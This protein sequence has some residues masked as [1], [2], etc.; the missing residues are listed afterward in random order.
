M[1]IPTVLVLLMGLLFAGVMPYFVFRN[2]DHVTRETVP[3]LFAGAFGVGFCAYLISE[4]E[5]ETT[6]VIVLVIGSVIEMGVVR[7]M[8]KRRRA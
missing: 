2:S 3:L 7:M 8:P 6:A 4:F 1:S 5:G